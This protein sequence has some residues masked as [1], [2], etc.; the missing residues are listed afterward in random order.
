[1]RADLLESAPGLGL[2][3]SPRALHQLLPRLLGLRELLLLEPVRRL[4]RAA[5]DVVRLL[6]GLAQA[7]AVLLEQLVG[8]HA[9]ALRRLDRVLDRLAAPVEELS[10]P[11]ESQALQQEQGEAE[12][13]QRPDHQPDIR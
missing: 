6:A 5:D 1:L 4:A 3:V 13:D 12:R 8:L 11:R 10:D 9:R 7:R 2:D